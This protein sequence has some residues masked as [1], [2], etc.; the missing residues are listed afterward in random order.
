MFHLSR[1]HLFTRRGIAIGV[2]VIFA[3]SG[4]S[5]VAIACEGA[6]EEHQLGELE[7]GR[8][9]YKVLPPAKACEGKIRVENTSTVAATIKV[10]RE[11]GIEC[12]IKKEGC[13]GEKLVNKGASCESEL[14]KPLILPEY[15][16]EVE[17]N[18]KKFTF[19]DLA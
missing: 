10:L 4:F 9:S 8:V 17:W 6:G 16:T 11:K 1:W 7:G 5:G 18:G 19:T 3:I 15:E 13:K 2:G 12:T 14:E